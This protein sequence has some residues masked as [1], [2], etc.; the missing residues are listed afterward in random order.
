[1]GAAVTVGDDTRPD[2]DNIQAERSAAGTPLLLV[3]D[4]AAGGTGLILFPRRTPFRPRGLAPCQPTPGQPALEPDDAAALLAA[5]RPCPLLPQHGEG[6]FGRPGLC[7]HRLDTGAAYPSGRP[8]L[9][10]ALPAGAVRVRRPPGPGR[11]RGQ[12]RRPGAGDRDRGG[13]R[14]RDPGPAH[15]DQPRPPAV[16]R[17]QLGSSLP[18]A[19]AG[20]GGPR[21]HRAADRRAHP[22]APPDRRRAVA[23]R[24]PPRP[25]RPRL[26]H[27]A[28]RGGS[29]F[30]LRQWRGLRPARRLEREHRAPGRASSLRPGHDRSRGDA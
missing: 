1:M 17:R 16:H 7:G 6:W 23:A 3:A 30:H 13:A 24:R 19:G 25:Y 10:T 22:A 18:L 15:A 29:R 14:R 2:L 11:G 28:G 26:R 9:V 21:L 27:H 8:R 4:P 5:A 20:R 12:D